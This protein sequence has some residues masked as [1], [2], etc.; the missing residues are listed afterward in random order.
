MRLDSEM[1]LMA[2]KIRQTQLSLRNAELCQGNPTTQS[3]PV[4]SEAS[5]KRDRYQPVSGEDYDLYA[6]SLPSRDP[7]EGIAAVGLVLTTM[8]GVG[9][10]SQSGLVGAAVGG[11]AGGIVGLALG[12]PALFR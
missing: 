4:P 3:E 5:R 9:I 8:L 7:R 1:S 11:L 6:Q 10:G 2:E 12:G